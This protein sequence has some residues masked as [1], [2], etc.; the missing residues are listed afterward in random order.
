MS[1]I[2]YSR[3]RVEGFWFRVSEIRVGEYRYQCLGIHLADCRS[4]TEN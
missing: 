3:F 4:P 1:V 2:V